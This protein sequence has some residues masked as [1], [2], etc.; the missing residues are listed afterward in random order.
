MGG[1][2]GTERPKAP[3]GPRGP[4]GPNRNYASV[5]FTKKTPTS[6]TQTGGGFFVNVEMSCLGT[7]CPVEGL[8]AR[9][10]QLWS[11]CSADRAGEERACGAHCGLRGGA[12]QSSGALARPTELARR[13]PGAPTAGSGA[14][15]SRL[16]R[17]VLLAPQ[18]WWQLDAR[19]IVAARWTAF[20]LTGSKS[21][22]HQLRA[23]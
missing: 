13:G 19:S 5:T 18:M 10:L 1:G 3:M 4:M 11:S 8:R 21:T 12:L 23:R 7:W 22:V 6:L 2:D 20:A 15:P 16:P 9:Q 17:D 14:A